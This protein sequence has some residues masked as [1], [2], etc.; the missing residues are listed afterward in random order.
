MPPNSLLSGES[1]KSFHISALFLP[2]LENIFNL[3]SIYFLI[4]TSLSFTILLSFIY[5]PRIQHSLFWKKGTNF[6][7]KKYCFADELLIA[8]YPY[9]FYRYQC[10][11]YPTNVLVITFMV[12]QY[13]V[14]QILTWKKWIWI[15]KE[16]RYEWM[17]FTS[18]YFWERFSF[19]NLG[20]AIIFLK[21]LI[22]YFWKLLG[23]QLIAVNIDKGKGSNFT[24]QFLYELY[25]RVSR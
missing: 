25:F 4:I 21:I 19:F 16:K 5:F 3:F 10:F 13:T 18:F 17:C 15:L 2:F 14:M 22:D 23:Y 20:F 8:P 11:C 9:L 24:L 1:F 6:K 12:D 7:K